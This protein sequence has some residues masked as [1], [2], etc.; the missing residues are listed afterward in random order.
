MANIFTV[1]PVISNK[2]IL[3]SVLSFG[4]AVGHDSSV[5]LELDILTG[6][7][8]D[9][10]F[11]KMELLKD[12]EY[13][14]KA[15]EHVKSSGVI[16]EAANKLK[17]SMSITPFMDN[18]SESISKEYITFTNIGIAHGDYAFILK[19]EFCLANFIASRKIDAG[20][21][22]DFQQEVNAILADFKIDKN[23]TTKQM[24]L[25]INSN[26]FE[27]FKSFSATLL[28]T[29]LREGLKTIKLDNLIKALI[30]GG[31]GEFIIV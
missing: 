8:G 30:D 2:V 6:R 12:K 13:L 5:S 29:T 18:V 4:E 26:Q 14:I 22:I 24:N 27:D 21:N 9:I 31:L 25:L 15:V 7:L 3:A 16:I 17:K 1:K 28:D 10:F 23:L 19:S 11:Q 20:E